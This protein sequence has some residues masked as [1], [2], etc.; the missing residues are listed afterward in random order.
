MPTRRRRPSARQYDVVDLRGHR[1]RRA[2]HRRVPRAARPGTLRWAI[3]GRNRDR[4]ETVRAGLAAIDGELA[5]LPLVTA[6]TA[7]PESLR[8]MAESAQVVATTVGPYVLYGDGGRR[9]LR[10]RRHRLPRPHRRAGVRQHQLRPPPPRGRAQRR[11]A[12]PRR[13][14]RL[15]PP[16]PR[17]PVHRPAA[18][19]GRAAD[20]AGLRAGIG[21]GLR[22][23][24]RLRA[25]R[26]LPAAAEP[27]RGPRPEGARP[28][29]RQQ[30]GAER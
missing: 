10:R 21:H 7:D 14:V 25:D 29:R 6:D 5:S 28:R 20:G 3:A 15:D 8:A 23:H 1:L 26:I 2:S 16:R 9:R 27:H 11:P 30:D 22:R 24:V 17:R 18:A 4:L 19:R 12:G 13:G